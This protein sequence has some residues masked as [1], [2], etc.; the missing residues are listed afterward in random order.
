MWGW[1]TNSFTEEG[2][3]E[4]EETLFGGVKGILQLLES[5]GLSGVVT[6]WVKVIKD[7]ILLDE[8]GQTYDIN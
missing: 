6:S 8:L 2:P 7:C 3:H 1:S 4:R 5:E